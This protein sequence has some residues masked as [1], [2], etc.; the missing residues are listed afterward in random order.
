MKVVLLKQRTWYGIGELSRAIHK[1]EFTTM[2]KL[3]NVTN[4]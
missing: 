4:S 2:K 1:R 3:A